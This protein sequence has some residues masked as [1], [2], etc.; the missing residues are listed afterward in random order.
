M[1]SFKSLLK[2]VLKTFEPESESVLISLKI[3]LKELDETIGRV[4][5]NFFTFSPKFDKS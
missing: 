2:N 1:T 5:N 4:S 3:Q